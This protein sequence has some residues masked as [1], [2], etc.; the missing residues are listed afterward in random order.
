MNKLLIIALTCLSSSLSAME[1]L[2]A[3]FPGIDALTQQFES[4]KVPHDIQQLGIVD[5]FAEQTMTPIQINT[6]I[7]SLFSKYTAEINT[8]DEKNFII[9]HLDKIRKPLVCALLK[10]HPEVKTAVLNP[11][12]EQ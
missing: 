6:T 12:T 7:D 10:Y 5:A 2:A 1:G 4:L 8:P 3:T 11:T 9:S